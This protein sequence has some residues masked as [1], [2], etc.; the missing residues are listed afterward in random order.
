MPSR[1]HTVTLS[2]SAES[3]FSKGCKERRLFLIREKSGY[4]FD[5]LTG[6][7]PSPRALPP[8]ILELAALSRERALALPEPPWVSGAQGQH[9][10]LLPRPNVGALPA[11]LPLA[12]RMGRGARWPWNH[13]LLSAPSGAQLGTPFLPGLSPGSH[14]TQLASQPPRV[15]SGSS[16]PWPDHISPLL[17]ALSHSLSASGQSLSTRQCPAALGDWP[18]PPPRVLASGL[19]ATP[20]HWASLRVTGPGPCSVF[21]QSPRWPSLSQPGCLLFAPCARSPL[22]CPLCAPARLIGAPGDPHSLSHG[23]RLVCNLIASLSSGDI[24]EIRNPV[25]TSLCPARKAGPGLRGALL[26][27]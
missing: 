5:H 4:C 22:P 1:V 8:L 19:P 27:G 14:C 13:V 11:I 21:C 17:K 3:I 26:S 23:A 12:H 24:L 9:L 16:D 20:G 18:C 10:N 2:T 25:C 15:V 6:E 7:R